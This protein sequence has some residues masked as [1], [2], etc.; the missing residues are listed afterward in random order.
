LALVY[1]QIG[2]EK[3]NNLLN[4]DRSSWQSRLMV[5]RSAL[6]IGWDNWFFGVGPGMFQKYYLDYQKYF[7]PYLEWAVPQPQNIFLAFWLQTGLVGLIGFFWLIIN[8]FR[9]VLRLLKKQKPSYAKASEGR[10]PLALALMAVMIYILVHGLL[11]ATFW[12]NDLALIFLTI[13]ALG[14]KAVRLSDS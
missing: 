5:W 3:L 13:A 11:D 14:Y 9:R 1:S 8:F 12:K 2:S 6:K 4:S 7:P 10:E